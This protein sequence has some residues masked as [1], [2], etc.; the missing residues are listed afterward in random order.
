MGK[1][2]KQNIELKNKNHTNDEKGTVAYTELNYQP[3]S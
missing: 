3:L 2:N 1:T